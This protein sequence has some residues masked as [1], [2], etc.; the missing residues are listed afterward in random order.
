[1]STDPAPVTG[2]L[3]LVVCAAPPVRRINE[4]IDVVQLDGWQVQVIATET[5]ASWLPT[6]LLANLTGRP[7]LHQ[8]RNPDE[9]SVLLRADAIAVVPATF[10]TLSKWALGIND[11]LALGVL[12]ESI[13]TDLPVIASPYAKPVLAR[14]PAFAGHLKVLADSGVRLTATEALRPTGDGQPFKWDVVADPL[15]SILTA[16][17]RRSAAST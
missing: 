5:A 9:P 11:S 4:F 17:T 3:Y 12:N 6:D 16:L 2:V 8:P 15:R 10:N 7:V 13:G 1:M 14:H